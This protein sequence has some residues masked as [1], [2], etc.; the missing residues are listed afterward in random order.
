[1]FSDE[2]QAEIN[3]LTKKRDQLLRKR[4]ALLQKWSDI[5]AKKWVKLKRHPRSCGYHIPE[6]E[7]TKLTTE[8]QIE[9]ENS[10][11]FTHTD[12]LDESTII[13]LKPLNQI[14]MMQDQCYTHPLIPKSDFEYRRMLTACEGVIPCENGPKLLLADPYGQVIT[15]VLEDL[16]LKEAESWVGLIIDAEIG[17]QMGSEEHPIRNAYATQYKK[18]EEVNLQK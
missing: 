4:S 12:V 11:F 7:M 2:E 15:S 16:T 13:S 3:E 9:W 10:F 5:Q 6:R 17:F 8:K 14:H 18:Y 1:M